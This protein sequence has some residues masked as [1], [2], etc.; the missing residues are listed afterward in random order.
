M[1]INYICTLFKCNAEKG[2]DI[3]EH[4]NILKITWEHVNSL[5]AEEFRISDLFFKIIISSSLLPILGQL[6]SSIYY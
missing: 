6:H 5:S 3:V 1:I 2:D 4:L